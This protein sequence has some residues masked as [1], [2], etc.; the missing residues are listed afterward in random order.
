MVLNHEHLSSIIARNARR[1]LI[2]IVLEQGTELS[3]CRHTSSGGP[4]SEAHV[5]R[6][7]KREIKT[8][9]QTIQSAGIMPWSAEGR[10]GKS[11]SAARLKRLL[12]YDPR[13]PAGLSGLRRQVRLRGFFDGLVEQP[14]N[15]SPAARF[16]SSSSPRRAGR[17]TSCRSSCWTRWTSCSVRD[18]GRRPRAALQGVSCGVS[19]GRVPLR[20]LREPE[21]I[22]TFGPPFAVLQLLRAGRARTPAGAQCGGNHPQTD[23]AARSRAAR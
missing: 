12:G 9:S 11:S 19:R 5:F 10:I 14:A 22:S 18:A 17:T 7:R 20:L 15:R 23:A 2:E 21:L 1:G 6:P 8:I 4:C 16:S 13:Y 3:T